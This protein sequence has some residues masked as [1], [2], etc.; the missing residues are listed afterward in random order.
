MRPDPDMSDT[1]DTLEWKACPDCY[2]EGRVPYILRVADHFYMKKAPRYKG[3]Y[4]V[5]AYCKE[6]E[7]QRAAA[8]RAKQKAERA[9]LKAEEEATGITPPALATLRAKWRAEWNGRSREQ[10]RMAHRNTIQ[11][12]PETHR[13]NVRRYIAAH[14]DSERARKAAWYAANREAVLERMRHRRSRL[15]LTSKPS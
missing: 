5:S 2:A 6:H 13:A 3:G 14:R 9:E 15:R 8:Q 10:R 1:T 4:R 12:N 7:K 11:A